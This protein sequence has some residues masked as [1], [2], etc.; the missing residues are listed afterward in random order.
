[1]RWSLADADLQIGQLH[2]GDSGAYYCSV[3][4]S[5]DIVGNSEERM[6]LLVLGE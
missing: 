5:D 4:T 3:I 6:E 2:W 1:M